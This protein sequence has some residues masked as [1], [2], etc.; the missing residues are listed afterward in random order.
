MKEITWDLIKETARDSLKKRKL[1]G[2]YEKRLE[3]ELNEVEKQGANRYWADIVISGKKFDSNKNHLLLPWLLG[4]LSGKADV[5]PIENR[6]DPLTTT[7]NHA[8]IAKIIEQ[9][10]KLP[11]DMIRDADVPD[12]DIDCLPEARD[13]IK[14]YA[15]QRYGSD[16]VASVGTWST[17][18]FK[19]A[20]QDAYRAL[21]FAAQDGDTGGGTIRYNKAIDLTTNLPDDVNEMKEGGYGICKGKVVDDGVEKECGTKHNKITCPSCGSEDTETPTL[22]RLIKDYKELREFLEEREGHKKVI[23]VASRLVGCIRNPGKH[24]GAI[25]I[26][27][28]SLFGNVPMIY[29]NDSKQWISTW[30]EGRSTQLSKFGYNKWDILGLKNLQ[31]IYE[32][33]KMI[34]TNHGISFGDVLEGLEELDPEKEQAGVYW[35]NGKK[36]RIPLHDK[37]ALELANAQKTDAVFQFDTDLA[38]RI[39]SNGVRSFWDLLIFNAMGHPGPMAMIPEYVERRDD[40]TQSWRDNEDEQIIDILG[41]THGVIVYQEQ[42][43]E[44]W[45]RIAGFTGPESQHAR[46]AVAKK[47]K[48]QLKPVRQRW[49]DGA[50]RF[51]GEAVAT[52]WWD[53]R[54][55]TFGRYAFNKCLSKDTIIEDALTGDRK[56]IEE[57]YEF[58]GFYINS[59]DEGG[60]VVVDECIRIHNNGPLDVYEIEFDDGTFET[61][62][63]THQF[64]CEDG[65]YHEVKEI[66]DEGLDVANIW[67]CRTGKTTESERYSSC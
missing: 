60:N 57:W 16:N 58:G 43:T 41:S 52:E 49:I 24:A 6:T 63:L 45:Q 19:N 14:E 56:T 5:D 25:I 27:D 7:S 38:K 54:M 2:I 59:V 44:L 29:N 8:A 20:I 39:L 31:Y 33:C 48:D 9:S 11:S 47:W 32:C 40:P 61:V 23:Q 53:D 65:R 30:T 28:R 51:L 64:L 34:E 35:K 1:N 18:L 36:Y 15:S 26:A 37:K 4:R 12:I 67:S 3:Y 42:L 66:I 21:G 10:G 17:Y 46:K 50:S 55:E 13:K 22:A 62:T